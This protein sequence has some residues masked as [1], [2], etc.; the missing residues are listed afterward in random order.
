[1]LHLSIRILVL[2][3]ISF[4][5]LGDLLS[6]GLS[7]DFLGLPAD[8][9]SGF[10]LF[11]LILICFMFYQA[12]MIF[13]RVNAFTAYLAMREKSPPGIILV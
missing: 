1:M 11:I 4:A 9:F 10:S 7:D 12:K 3:T 2:L 13:T 5:C 8:F 6:D